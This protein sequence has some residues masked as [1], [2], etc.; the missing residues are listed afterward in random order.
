[1]AGQHQHRYPWAGVSVA[2]LSGAAW[3]GGAELNSADTAWILTSTGLV[4]FMTMPGLALLYCGLVRTR[5]ALSVIVQCFAV[6]ALVSVLWMLAGYTF[7]LTDGGSA[8]A[9]IG[10]LSRLFLRGLTP[11]DLSGN[12][13]EVVFCM[14]HLTFAIFAPALIIGSFVERTTF[15]TTLWFT[16]IWSLL[17]YVPVCHWMWGGGWLAQL[18]AMDFAGG[19]VVH[20]TAGL[21]ALTAAWYIGPRRGFPRTHMPP[22]N[23]ALTAAGA[24][25]LA[26]GWH[27][28]SA[29][30]ALMATGAAGIAML[31]THAG[32]SVGCLVWMGLEWIRFGKPT[33]L[34]ILTG[35]IAGLGIIS[36]AAGFV[37]PTGAIIMG[38]IGGSVCFFAIH[39]IK[40][41]LAIDDTLD[42]F[43]VHGVGGMIGTVLTAPFALDVFGGGG[44]PSGLAVGQQIIIQLIAVAVAGAWSM[45]VSLAILK[46]LS[47][48]ISLRVRPDI[49]NEG[50]DVAMHNGKAYHF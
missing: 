31:N 34:G 38:A 41:T 11:D 4:L 47:R 1:M 29:G 39:W 9:W 42:V 8:N 32:A 12:L 21:A 50:L 17:V 23:L 5:N 16:A 10:G 19:V 15:P 36:P 25:I 48:F 49:E 14:Y 43:P 22:H 24:G 40:R 46:L 3:A 45:L 33:M 27:G 44:I 26:V 2:V 30:S 35:M 20:T 18:G 37:G 28:F 7:A 6:S 13:P